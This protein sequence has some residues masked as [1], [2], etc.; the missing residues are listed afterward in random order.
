MYKGKYYSQYFGMPMEKGL[1]PIAVDIA[2]GP[3]LT[4]IKTRLKEIFDVLL[5]PQKKL[6]DDFSAIRTGV[7]EI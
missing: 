4:E 5:L 2:V 3:I 7:N 6:D 1:S